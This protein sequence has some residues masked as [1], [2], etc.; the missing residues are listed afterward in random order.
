MTLEQMPKV[1]RVALLLRA[2]AIDSAPVVPM[3]LDDRL[4]FFRE[5]LTLR[6]SETFLAPGSPILFHDSF[7]LVNEA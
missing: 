6:A 4:R 5:T 1:V 7:K 2:S 3:E